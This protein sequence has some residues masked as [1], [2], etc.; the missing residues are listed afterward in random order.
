MKKKK[1]KITKEY[2]LQEIYYA[3]IILDEIDKSMGCNPQIKAKVKKDY[4][5]AEIAP[6]IQVYKTIK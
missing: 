3:K 1:K 4:F 6:L 2:I 5:I